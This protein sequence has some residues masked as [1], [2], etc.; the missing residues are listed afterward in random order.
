M[1]IGLIGG[2][3]M[4][5]LHARVVTQNPETTLAWVADPHEQARV[6]LAAKYPVRDSVSPAEIR[7]VDGLIIA[8]TTHSHLEWCERAIEEGVAFLVEKPLSLVVKEVEWVAEAALRHGVPFTVGFVER[9]NNAVI[10]AHNVIRGS[11]L[12][13]SAIRHSPYGSR[14]AIGTE[15]DLMI[16]DLDLALSFI[17][18]DVEFV[19]GFSARMHPQ[20][21]KS[22]SDIASA[23][24]R[25]TGGSAAHLSASRLA[26]RK[27]RLLT[28]GNLERSAEIDLLRS[29]ITVY[30]HVLGEAVDDGPGYRQETVIEI[31]YLQPGVEPLLGQ[32]EHFMMLIK[33]EVDAVSE[34]E[35]VVYPHRVMAAIEDAAGAVAGTS[36]GIPRSRFGSSANDEPRQG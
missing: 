21:A 35:S 25:F 12:M 5:S 23:A 14:V 8:S 13:F 34:I 2:G 28:I 18:D 1:K 30:R 26:Q 15:W 3:S 4:G 6:G 29:D 16:H 9:F 20:S 32:L 7:R 36:R 24:I 19:S 22:T 17:D 11:V 10:A 33:G 31:P 27:I